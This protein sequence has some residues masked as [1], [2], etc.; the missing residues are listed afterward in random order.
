MIIK[1]QYID[2]A[3]K[4]RMVVELS[5]GETTMLKFSEQPTTSALN[6]IEANYIANSAVEK[7]AVVQY[8]ILQ[9]RDL[10]KAVVIAIKANPS[11]TLTQYTTHLNTKQWWEQAIINTY[12]YTIAVGLAEKHGVSLSN[13]TQST[14]WTQVRNWIANTPAR[15]I[16]KIL[17]GE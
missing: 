5:N 4:I 9:H 8:E 13:Y 10:F 2:A 14:V 16:S 1:E 11:M 3:G 17:F 7:L 6:E 12:M 15:N